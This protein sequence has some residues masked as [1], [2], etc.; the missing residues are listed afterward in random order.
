MEYKPTPEQI[1]TQK[2]GTHIVL[3]ANA[4]S[5]KTRVLTERYLKIIYDTSE[6]E[7]NKVVAITFTEKAAN[8]MLERIV[9]Q[10]DNEFANA[11]NDAEKKKFR[12]IKRKLSYAKIETIH[13]FCLQILRD[14][15]IDA[16]LQPNFK[17]ISTVESHL[18]K[19]EAIY[20]AFAQYLNQTPEEN[21][22][23]ENEQTNESIKQILF[24]Q[25]KPKE[26]KDFVEK[27]LAKPDIFHN[28]V[29]IYRQNENQFLD[30]VKQD[31]LN[32]VKNC[33]SDFVKNL[34][35][36]LNAIDEKTKNK[37]WK[38][39]TN[40]EFAENLQ[41]QLLKKFEQFEQS[42]NDFRTFETVIKILIELCSVKTNKLNY[43]IAKLFKDTNDNEKFELNFAGEKK[44]L[45]ASEYRNE[46]IN[47][48]SAGENCS[49]N[50]LLQ[51][52]L[53]KIIIEITQL[54]KNEINLQKQKLNGIDFDDMLL[55][56]RN[57]LLENPKIAETIAAEYSNI[58]VDEF[59]DTNAIQYDIIKSL[60][61]SLDLQKEVS[62]DVSANIS[63]EISPQKS[64]KIFIVGDEKQ[65]IYR[66]RNADV[67]VFHQ[68][69]QEV[70]ISNEHFFKNELQKT[71][72]PDSGIIKLTATFRMQPA[73]T[74][75]VN[76]ICSNIFSEHYKN[77]SG[78][79]V[80]KI[81]YS[82]LICGRNSKYFL[83]KIQPNALLC[84]DFGSVKFLLT[85]KEKDENSANQ[86]SINPDFASQN[87][88]TENDFDDEI[89]A[90]QEAELLAKYINFIVNGNSKSCFIQKE[91]DGKI[92]NAKPQYADIAILFRSRTQLGGLVLE[93]I[94]KQIPFLL[95][96]GSNFFNEQEIY[97]LTSYLRFLNNPKDDLAL[98][99]IMLSPFFRLNYVDILNIHC[100]NCEKN[101]EGISEKN[102]IS[103]WDKVKIFCEKNYSN[104]NYA[105][106]KIFFLKNELEKQI[107]IAQV[108]SITHLLRTL[109]NT[110]TW[111]SNSINN[112]AEK[113][114]S[115]NI[116]KFISIAREFQN[117]GF[118]NLNDFIVEVDILAEISSD[119]EAIERKNENAVT[120]QTIHSSKG[121]EFPIVI[122]YNLYANK[123]SVKSPIISK[124]YG[125]VFD[126]PKTIFNENS[127]NNFSEFSKFSENINGISK[128]N[129]NEISN[130][131]TKILSYILAAKNEESYETAEDMRL[132][133]VAMTRAKDHLI[134]SANLKRTKEGFE[135]RPASFFRKIFGSLNFGDEIIE[136][137]I[138]SAERKIVEPICCDVEL[139]ND[140]TVSKNISINCELI[141]A[142]DEVATMERT[143]ENTAESAC[144]SKDFVVDD[145]LGFTEKNRFFSFTELH[146]FKKNQA[147]D[148]FAR[149]E[150]IKSLLGFENFHLDFDDELH[151]KNFDY[152]NASNL[153]EN[154]IFGSI[155]G[156]IFHNI[157]QKINDWYDGSANKLNENF[158]EELIENE[159][160]LLNDEQKTAKNIFV[161]KCKQIVNTELFQA[162]KESLRTAKFEYKLHIPFGENFYSGVID[163]LLCDENG[164]Y[165]IWDWKT[166]RIANQATVGV[167]RENYELQMKMYIY[168]LMYLVPQQ[169]HYRARLLF[170]ELAKENASN[171]EWTAEFVFTQSDK[172]SLH[173]EIENH[174][175][176]A[177]V[178]VGK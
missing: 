151:S 110:G 30:T 108:V 90:S 161:E 95:A 21:Q 147:N 69:K 8:E 91:I 77:H 53:A 174:I 109:L 54:A 5:G 49:E 31:F 144:H 2:L 111:L 16:G 85:V 104:E 163:C 18:I 87:S 146:Q 148:K 168:F 39:K 65:S 46:I 33:L 120:L 173:S 132:L 171:E 122:L 125:I 41:N 70:K 1:E 6:N 35:F 59:Q 114:I 64:P 176:N 45:T 149:S 82:N 17:T 43:Y 157:L 89:P 84:D 34:K 123:K 158:L 20:N 169:T 93:L 101:C 105:S 139:L 12:Q 75:F 135:K 178:T 165:E 27:L 58:M 154:T 117:R 7:I 153:S 57:L 38:D 66:F 3:S 68:A 145:A 155:K 4:G 126:S 83:E 50:I 159:L 23:N 60:V 55:I 51:F 175:C 128:E 14:Y 156:K 79:K 47:I 40:K 170:T 140:A 37:I 11:K 67:E 121:L 32:F 97:D 113:Q 119:T 52:N 13:S 99:A 19:R 78:N 29:E 124:K 130:E 92:E 26:I 86:N 96:S 134:L 81:D 25:Y 141:N 160:I 106:E 107:E 62:A 28:I 133:Y 164:D 44:K 102:E 63:A 112:R 74:A 61:P 127:N 9:K 94:N 42:K 48:F 177:I 72:I 10:V 76:K 136:R 88:E 56:T 118:S 15:A 103:L 73:I 100:E 162:Y 80:A 138:V 166:N 36:S 150:Y 143:A 172:N 71:K 142:I 22:K 115:N 167:L 131:R 116:E 98:V 137:L 152:S 24:T 129:S